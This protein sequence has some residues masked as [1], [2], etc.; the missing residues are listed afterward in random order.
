[1]ERLYCSCG[2]EI[3]PQ[4]DGDIGWLFHAVAEHRVHVSCGIKIGPFDCCTVVEGDCLELMKQ[5]PDG[6]VDA[7]ITDPPYG[8]DYCHSGG[9][10][11]VQ[12]RKH[13]VAIIGDDRPFDPS[14][15]L[16][17][18][19]VLCFG[20]DHYAQ[21]LPEGRWLVWDKLN[22]WESLDTFSDVEIAWHSRRGASRIF[23]YLWKG[24]KQDGE[25]GERR[26]HPTQKPVALMTW[27]INQ[28]GDEAQTILD[29]FC[30]SGTTLVAA[31]KLGR[32]FLGF[33]IS[34]EY[35][36]IARKRIAL[37][38]AQ[39][40]LFPAAAPEQFRTSRRETMKLIFILFLG[41]Q[42]LHLLATA[43]YA[44]QSTHTSWQSVR[45]YIEV[46]AGKLLTQLVLSI[47][48]ILIVMENPDALGRLG[49]PFKLSPGLAIVLGWFVDSLLDKLL[50]FW[51][52]K[53]DVQ[54]S[55]GQP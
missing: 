16:R 51:G 43:F 45:Q 37:V 18:S 39:P 10:R 42:V 44:A 26:V 48:L 35:C 49:I 30:G 40:Q 29:P 19:N 28:A 54:T 15:L 53:R 1:L 4:F 47:A 8:I 46:N 34:P 55:A 41:S 12:Q 38:E 31:K 24:V 50:G 36:E 6:A 14:L 9:G 11:G 21:R 20:A 7:V 2:W 13:A 27:C 17:F 33:E 5:L 52:L 32:H 22:K 3:T 25:K 23:S